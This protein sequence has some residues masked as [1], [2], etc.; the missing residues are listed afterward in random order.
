MRAV[1][2]VMLCWAQ[3]SLTVKIISKGQVQCWVT[4]SCSTL[5]NHMDHSPA[6]SSVHGFPRQVYWSG[7][8]FPT[9]G[10]FPD[11]GIEP[12]PPAGGFLTTE[13][14]GKPLTYRMGSLSSES[15]S[16]WE[17]C[18]VLPTCQVVQELLGRSVWTWGW[19]FVCGHWGIMPSLWWSGAPGLTNC[20][21]YNSKSSFLTLA[22]VVSPA[23]SDSRW[24]HAKSWSQYP[25]QSLIALD[26]RLLLGL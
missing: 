16:S 23:T 10:D 11:P 24:A 4:Q 22:F 13:L 12:R 26:R 5:C 20:L 1:S 25:G 3:T 19:N 14:C 15:V 6:G 17:S 7:L 18:P 9:P 2:W 8:P 21:P